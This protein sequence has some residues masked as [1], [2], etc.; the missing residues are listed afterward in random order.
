M[1]ICARC[2]TFILCASAPIGDVHLSISNV[3]N[4]RLQMNGVRCARATWRAPSQLRECCKLCAGRIPH[5]LTD[6][7]FPHFH[8]FDA[9]E[10]HGNC[11]AAQ[12]K[13]K[14]RKWRDSP[15]MNPAKVCMYA[16]RGNIYDLQFI[17]THAHHER[18][19]HRT[20]KFKIYAK[21]CAGT[22]QNKT[23]ETNH[24][25]T[26]HWSARARARVSTT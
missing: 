20:N 23:H 25:D 18:G 7:D 24:T 10:E 15:L 21:C 13:R 19:I 1:T 8:R 2:S 3:R 5:V 4:E 14:K 17:S 12:A 11:T 22:E 6:G 26:E 16:H 9:V